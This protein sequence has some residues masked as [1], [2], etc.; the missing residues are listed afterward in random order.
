[1][2]S[3]RRPWFRRIL[4]SGLFTAQGLLVRA[5][6]IALVFLL[7]HAIGLREYT[8]ILSGTSPTGNRG[9]LFAVVLAVLYVL[10]WFGFVLVVPILVLAAAMLAVV[11]SL[12][13]LRT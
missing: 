4:G 10:S 9:D 6:L 13:R 12:A 11:Q 1:M 5:L 8:T 7:L 2:S 3:D